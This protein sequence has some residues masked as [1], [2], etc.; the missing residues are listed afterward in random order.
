MGDPFREGP[1]WGLLEDDLGGDF[2][3]DLL[4]FVDAFGADVFPPAV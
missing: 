2:L 3:R 4:K 1:W